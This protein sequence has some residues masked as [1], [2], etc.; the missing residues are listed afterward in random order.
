[1]DIYYKT[2]ER[3]QEF[4][5]KVENCQ[6][7]VKYFLEQRK[8]HPVYGKGIL[9]SSECSRFYEN[10]IVMSDDKFMKLAGDTVRRSESAEWFEARRIRISGSSKVHSIISRKRKTVEAL[11]EQIL[12]PKKVDVDA[13]R[14]GIE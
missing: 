11:I 14:Y 1:M 8:N 7:C 13:T 9:L 12:V 10:F 2:V 6:S 4:K 5:S 3:E